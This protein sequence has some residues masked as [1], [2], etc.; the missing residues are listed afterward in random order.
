VLT[1]VEG[2]RWCGSVNCY[3]EPVE[4]G[5]FCQRHIRDWRLRIGE[6]LA[7]SL[8]EVRVSL[9][10]CAVLS[11][12]PIAAFVRASRTLDHAAYV[13]N[14]AQEKAGERLFAAQNFT[15][16]FHAT[17]YGVWGSADYDIPWPVRNGCKRREGD[18]LFR[19]TS[20]EL[21]EG[22]TAERLEAARFKYLNLRNHLIPGGWFPLMP[23]SGE[24]LTHGFLQS[25]E[26]ALVIAGISDS[27][28]VA[29]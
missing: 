17:P 19:L 20:E 1:A 27:V 12:V 4:P 23:G 2:S 28:E 15:W 16:I 6:Q 7:D 14:R 13:F 18:R 11:G 10:S 5:G 25:V 22:I 21:E 29:A 24:L 9:A 3:E 8:L 26:V